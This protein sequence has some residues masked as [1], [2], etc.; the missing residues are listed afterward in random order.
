LSKEKIINYIFWVLI[1]FIFFRFLRY[2]IIFGIRFWYLFIPLIVLIYF[3]SKKKKN[4]PIPLDPNK[5]VKSYFEPK[6]ED[7]DQKK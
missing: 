7:D 1:V 4:K 3:Y 2:I 5:E 6:I